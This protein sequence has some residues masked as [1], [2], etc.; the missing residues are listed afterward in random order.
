MKFYTSISRHGNNL[1]YRGYQDGSRIK[2]KIKFAPTLYVKGKGNSKFNA[3]DGT[4]V[5][6][7]KLESMRDA[8]EFIEKYDGVENFTIYGNTNYIAQYIAEEFPNEIQFDRSKIRVHNIDIEVMSD[9][10]FPEPAQ[11][12]HPITSICIYDNVLDTYYV[13]ALGDYDTNKAL[14]KDIS[15][16]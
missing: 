13:W 15:I 7:I 12:A 9:A 16:R 6:P 4:N 2:R 8:K 14:L 11:A 3:L 5:D 10:G 1:L